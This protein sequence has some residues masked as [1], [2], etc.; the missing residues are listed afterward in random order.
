MS[1]TRRQFLGHAGLTALTASVAG[2][3]AQADDAPLSMRVA[4]LTDTHLPTTR[5]EIAPRVAKLIDDIQSA[6]QPPDLFLFGGD[7]VM[8]IDRAGTPED[9]A[10]GQM[11]LWHK[12]VMERLRV[13][14]LSV[15]GNHDIWWGAGNGEEK[16]FAIK[17]YNMPH[18]Y[19]ARTH[20]GW[21]FIL[22]DTF[23]KAGCELDVPQWEWLEA[24]LAAHAEPT[25]VVTH[26]PILSATHFLEPSTEKG[27]T[28][29][30]PA[31]WS[32]K[33]A[34]RFRELFRKFPQVRLALSG[35][36]HTI[37]RVEIDETTYLCGGAVS[38]S[39]WAGEYLGF[40]PSWHELVLH[41]DGKWSRSIHPWA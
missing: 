25:V 38:G 34:T 33:G 30:I 29:Q 35:H 31:G 20:R 7:N 17:H 19:Y 9:D 6:P 13:P 37:D 27:H 3:V 12:T 22:L 15:I 18:R 8:N 4:F 11:E 28:Y 36:M 39:W 23:H 26:A 40:P 1:P 5:P 14:S 21:R 10:R 32:P 24:E 2:A 16:A 41:A